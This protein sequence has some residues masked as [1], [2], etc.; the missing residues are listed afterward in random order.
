MAG[1]KL[2]TAAMRDVFTEVSLSAA[3]D[4]I[5]L[6]ELPHM[7][8]HEAQNLL[9]EHAMLGRLQSF[10]TMDAEPQA[11][12]PPPSES[13]IKRGGIHSSQ[14]RLL[15]LFRGKLWKSWLEE[16]Y[17]EISLNTPHPRFSGLRGPQ[18]YILGSLFDI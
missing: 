16:I 7:T 5:I 9:A 1:L 17:I 18:K 12:P 13:W 3:Y 14:Q 6:G 15:Q 10:Q 11:P 8:R 2:S 4:S